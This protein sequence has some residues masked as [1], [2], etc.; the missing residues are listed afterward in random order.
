M[1]RSRTEPA[2]RWS[3]LIRVATRLLVAAY[4]IEA[5]LLLCLAP[6][7]GLWQRNAF[8]VTLSW[9]APVVGNPFV[10]GA[11][12][13]VGL[14]TLAAGLRDLAAVFFGGRPAAPAGSPDDAGHMP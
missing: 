5:G 9:L 4:L 7:T 14:V 6:W 3:R 11:V 13:G 12:T 10:R 2:V 8:A 1:I